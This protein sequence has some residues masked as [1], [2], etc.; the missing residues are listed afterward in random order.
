L[1]K[2]EAGN[3]QTQ[4]LIDW[5]ASISVSSASNRFSLY[6][7]EYAKAAKL[8]TEHNF[9]VAHSELDSE[10]FR[11][12]YWAICELLQWTEIHNEFKKKPLLPGLRN[13]IVRCANGGAFCYADPSKST[14]ERDFTYELFLNVLLQRAGAQMHFPESHDNPDLLG[15]VKGTIFIAECKRPKNSDG[16]GKAI[17]D[18]LGQLSSRIATHSADFCFPAICMDHLLNPNAEIFT[19]ENQ[20]S[21]LHSMKMQIATSGAVRAAMI[22]MI[23]AT[24]EVIGT[25]L[26]YAKPALVTGSNSIGLAVYGEFINRNY[27]G[28]SHPSHAVTAILSKAFSPVQL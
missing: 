7:K 10:S 16:V 5:L 18:A 11:R 9:N 20:T 21:V 25:L 28:E 24:P 26:T 8:V 4:H 27:L 2:F 23:K 17:K 22:A 1:D 14:K 19:A 13:L 3:E 12:R 15:E 6:K